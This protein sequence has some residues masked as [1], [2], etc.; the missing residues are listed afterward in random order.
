[1]QRL[2]EEEARRK[3]EEE[4]EVRRLE[5]EETRAAKTE[6]D[7]RHL[8]EFNNEEPEPGAKAGLYHSPF[9]S[10]LFSSL[11]F[12]FFLRRNALV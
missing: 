5:E 3:R 6:A 1:M 2:R 8:M 9:I 10:S 12:S 4:E 7:A 11:S